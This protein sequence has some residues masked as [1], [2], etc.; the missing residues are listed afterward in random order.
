MSINN[1]DIKK[2]YGL[3][4][5][6]CNICKIGLFEDAVHIGQMAH[7]IAKSPGGA[8]GDELNSNNNSYDNL[9][10]LCANDHIRVDNDPVT[11]TVEK[12]KSIKNEHEQFIANST[13][14]SP[15]SLARRKSDIT[16]LNAYF[17]Y[18]PFLRVRSY[19]DDLPY[20]FHLDFLT[21]D[22]Q[23]DCILKDLPSSYP[24]NDKI[25]N[26]N[27]YDFICSYRKI[28]YCLTGYIEKDNLCIPIFGGANN[29]RYCHFNT[30]ELPF[31]KIEQIEFN[32]SSACNECSCAYNNLISYNR[33]YYPEVN[34]NSPH[35]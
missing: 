32:I 30:N 7:V 2:L 8:R 21:F 26:S 24:L 22:D 15:F 19:L 13:D 18:T 20:R 5:G 11:Y 28:L 16:F 23:F 31:D 10:L 4:A 12:L 27:F 3:S 33:E 25:L 34:M 1:A 17:H 9:I 6:K 29:I 35:F 14:F